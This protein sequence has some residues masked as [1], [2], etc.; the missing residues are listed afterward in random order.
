MQEEGNTA[1]DALSRGDIA[2]ASLPEKERI[3]LDFVELLT[4]HAYRTTQED[5][6]R[7]R[8]AG[9]SDEQVAE[10]VYIT[11]LFA[12]F[13]RV[14]DAFGLADPGYTQLLASGGTP[15]TPATKSG[16]T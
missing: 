10:C 5:V 7:V 4:R 8:D 14:A 11:A 1:A 2:A 6:Q 12:L 13:N 3:L 15:L 16:L 9:W